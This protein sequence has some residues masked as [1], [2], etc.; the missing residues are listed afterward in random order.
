L[1]SNLQ[2][3]S[4]LNLGVPIVN[5]KFPSINIR[6]SV[7]SKDRNDEQQ[8]IIKI[9]NAKM[10]TYLATRNLSTVNPG[11]ANVDFQHL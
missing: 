6:D 7:Q 4:F 1:S 3:S 11:D 8:A 10:L 9:F 2:V 5:A